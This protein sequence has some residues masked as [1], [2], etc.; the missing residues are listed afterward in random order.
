MIQTDNLTAIQSY[1]NHS[2]INYSLLSQLADGPENVGKFKESDSLSFGGLVDCRLF[3]PEIEEHEYIMLPKDY[4]LSDNMKLFADT[5]VKRHKLA[6][7]TEFEPTVEDLLIARDIA[8]FKI[9]GDALMKRFNAE[10]KEYADFMLTVGDKKVIDP[11]MAVKAQAMV[12]LVKSHEWTRKYFEAGPG[13]ELIYQKDIYWEFDVKMTYASLPIETLMGKAL[14]DII[15]VDHRAKT[16]EPV[17]FKTIGMPVKQFMTNYFKYKYFYQEEWYMSG[18]RKWTNLDYTLLPF[19]FMVASP[20]N[21]YPLL[22]TIEKSME[23]SYIIWNGDTAGEKRTQ[24]IYQ[25]IEDYLW[26]KVNGFELDRSIKEDRGNV[27]KN[28][29]IR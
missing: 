6:N 4:K 9:S 5:L 29:T 1:R 17:D 15:R 21:D 22:Y 23:D 3:T 20:M 13:I 2:G 28:I 24:G 7:R 16:V 26:Y 27:I 8:G 18:M 19:K 14:L 11:E 25:L 12:D 10:A